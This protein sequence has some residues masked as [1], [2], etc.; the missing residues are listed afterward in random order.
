MSWTSCAGRVCPVSQG[1]HETASYRVHF[2]AG[3]LEIQVSESKMVIANLQAVAKCFI[4][5]TEGSERIGGSISLVA[6]ILDVEYAKEPLVITTRKVHRSRTTV[7]PP[8]T[9]G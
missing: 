7:W 4:K 8:N 1:L 3:V 9:L 2:N 6:N 5:D